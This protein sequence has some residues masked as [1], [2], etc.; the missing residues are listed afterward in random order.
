[1]LRLT[2]LP[3]PMT[4]PYPMRTPGKDH[5]VAADPHL[6]LDHDRFQ[7]PSEVSAS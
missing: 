6:V 5:R 7:E 4:D 3:A 2:T 1:M